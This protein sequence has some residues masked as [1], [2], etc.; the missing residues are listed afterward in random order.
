[1]PLLKRENIKGWK[2]IFSE[3]GGWLA[4]A[5][6]IRSIGLLL[7]AKGV[8]F[9][10]GD[11][12]SFKRPLFAG[13]GYT[14]VGVETVDGSKYY[15]DKVVLAAGAWSPTLVDLEDQCCSKVSTWCILMSRIDQHFRR[16]CMHRCV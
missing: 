5:K 4:A 7:K 2:A 11:A 9:W 14:C 1:M 15:G 6:A 8:K 13:D 3:D 12:G 10:F 16:G